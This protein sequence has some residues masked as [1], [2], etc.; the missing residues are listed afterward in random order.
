MP[1][2]TS[3]RSDDCFSDFTS[4]VLRAFQASAPAPGP[5][6]RAF[7]Q[8]AYAIVD[9]LHVLD[10]SGGTTYLLWTGTKPHRKRRR[11]EWDHEL[12]SVS[13]LIEAVAAYAATFTLRGH[14]IAIQSD[15]NTRTIR[16]TPSLDTRAG[17]K[18]P[19]GAMV[20]GIKYV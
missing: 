10:V 9:L 13:D 18:E 15:L 4:S 19:R 2:T 16:V 1:T 6:L 8:V 17:R 12:D 5:P 3:G 11:N 14:A 7:N 20:I